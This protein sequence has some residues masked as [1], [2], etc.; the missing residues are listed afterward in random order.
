MKHFLLYLFFPCLL[1]SQTASKKIRVLFL[2][3]SYTYV[4]NLPQ[5][6][7]DVAL[8]NGDSVVFD[9]YCPGGYT[10]NNHASDATT[11]LKISSGN[12]DYV[13]LQA[14]SQEPSFSPGQ[15]SSQ[16][17]PHAIT[18]DSLI[19][20]YN[21]CAHTVFYETWGRKNG[22]ASNCGFYPPVC[23]YAGMQNR[24][25]D[26][27]KLF[28]D[29]VHDIMAPVGEAWRLART[30]NTLINFYQADE[31][32]PLLEGSYLAAVVFYETLFQKSVLSN[33]YNP[34]IGTATL[35]MLQ[36]VAHQLVTDSAVITNIPK[37]FPVAAFSYSVQNASDFYFQSGNSGFS[38]QWYFGD[39]SQ[40]SSLNPNHSY[41]ISGTYTVS[42][43]LKNTA[44]CHL[45][46]VTQVIT[47]ASTVGLPDLK[48]KALEIFPNPC[49]EFLIIKAPALFEKNKSLLTLRNYLGQVLLSQVYTGYLN[50]SSLQKGIYYLHLTTG[51]V[52]SNSCFVKNE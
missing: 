20:H 5:L 28:A 50:T 52:Q 48:N 17:L 43:V 10:F 11:L 21:P 3:N 1:Y 23:T 49:S 35:S 13:V 15:V 27:Y 24:L 34:G 45:D 41:T 31:S 14:Q 36:Q 6:I 29:T 16:T 40:S 9:S 44:G 30:T 7:K 51:E 8:A 33:T 42:L 22:D 37:Y 38:Q 12:W 47:V 18:L 19:K 25:R 4:N 46:S 32:H 26:S 39:G 2:G